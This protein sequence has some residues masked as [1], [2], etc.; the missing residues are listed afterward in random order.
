MRVNKRLNTDTLKTP[1][2]NSSCYEAN[3]ELLKATF[4]ALE[5]ERIYMLGAECAHT[6]ILSVPP[7]MFI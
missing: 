2:V 7:N 3:P 4:E 1:S 5:P 6:A